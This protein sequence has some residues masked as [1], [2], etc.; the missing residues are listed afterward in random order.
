[1][2][3]KL[4]LRGLTGELRGKEFTFPRPAHAILGRSRKCDVRLAGDATV[5]RQHCII[6]LDNY[7]AWVQDLGSCNGTLVNGENIGQR[8]KDNADLTFLQSLRH[9]LTDGDELR[10]CNNLF[11]V[12]LNEIVQPGEQKVSSDRSSGEWHLAVCI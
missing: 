11:A 6:E 2:G 1:M 3:I 4:V 10:I 8:E 12:C 5:S 7:G 9:P